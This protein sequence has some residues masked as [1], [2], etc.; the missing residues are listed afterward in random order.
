M[1]A[2]VA[3]T[4][5]V[6]WYLYDDVRLSIVAGDFIDRTAASG[7][8]IAVS[9]ITLAEIVDLI[10]KGKVPANVYTGVKAARADLEHV[11]HET[12]LTA[13]VV[14]AMRTVSRAEVPDMPD[15][16]VAATA[17]HLNVPILSRDGRIRAASLNTVW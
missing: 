4:H 16:I 2:G 3:G 17:V 12:P 15:R 10:E 11:F 13:N 14:E 8:R 9:S 6:I 7:R 1:I 5:T